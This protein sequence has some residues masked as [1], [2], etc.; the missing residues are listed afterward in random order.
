MKEETEH[1]FERG[2]GGTCLI[3]WPGCQGVG[4]YSRGGERLLVCGCS[5][6]E[7]QYTKMNIKNTK[8]F[9]EA[10]KFSHNHCRSLNIPCS[11]S[12]LFLT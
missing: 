11:E 5:L 4:T 10:Y 6:E 8:S 2:G 7:T 12:Y 3:L 1:L 9:A